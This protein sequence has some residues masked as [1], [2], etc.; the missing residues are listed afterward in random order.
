ML[1]CT[2]PYCMT[3]ALAMDERMTEMRRLL[4][5]ELPEDNYFLLKYI[6]QFLNEV[7][8]SCNMMITLFVQA[9]TSTQV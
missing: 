6:L 4:H 5:D 2:I 8:E 1:Y 9:T 3:T 7:S